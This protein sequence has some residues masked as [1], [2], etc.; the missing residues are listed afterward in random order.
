M[1]KKLNVAENNDHIDELLETTETLIK[2]DLEYGSDLNSLTN[3]I[4]G[5]TS[6]SFLLVTRQITASGNSS[7]L[8]TLLIN[9]VIILVSAVAGRFALR[10]YRYNKMQVLTYLAI[11]RLHVKMDRSQILE[12]LQ[13][14]SI[15][16]VFHNLILGHY[17]QEEERKIVEAQSSVYRGFLIFSG[18]CGFLCLVL[19]LRQLYLLYT[20]MSTIV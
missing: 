15:F 2:S 19:F 11:Q 10:T 7:I 17:L 12:D 9:Y 3:W 20:L 5:L 16:D 4:V 8:K 1:D 14:T 6:G 18:T 13:N